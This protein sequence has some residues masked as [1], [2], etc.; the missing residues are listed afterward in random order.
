MLKCAARPEVREAAFSWIGSPFLSGNPE[1]IYLF[2]F[3]HSCRRQVVSPDCKMLLAGLVDAKGVFA[4]PESAELSIDGALR[5][6]SGVRAAHIRCRATVTRSHLAPAMHL[7]DLAFSVMLC[8]RRSLGR[9]QHHKVGD[10]SDCDFPDR[11]LAAL[12][13]L[14]MTS[15]KVNDTK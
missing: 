1:P 9:A 11:Y 5:A 12:L 6:P 10:N 4:V 3:P 8:S 7:L 2:V 15:G 14:L 13:R